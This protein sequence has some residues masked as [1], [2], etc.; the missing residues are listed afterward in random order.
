[1]DD[2][3]VNDNDVKPKVL[4]KPFQIMIPLKYNVEI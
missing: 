1:M 2:V 4:K 3:S